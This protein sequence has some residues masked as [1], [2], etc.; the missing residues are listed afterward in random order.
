MCGE[1]T[2]RTQRRAADDRPTMGPTASVVAR[3]ARLTVRRFAPGD[4]VE[5]GELHN[6][7]AVMSYLNNG[8]S[9]PEGDV[10]EELAAWIDEYD[11]SDALGCWAI[12]E[13][14]SGRFV[15]WIHFRPR[16]RE[17]EPELGFR[18]RRACWGRGFAT[19]ASRALIDRG[20]A[21]LSIDR[22]YAH[23]MS[24]HRAS[25][26]VMEK[27]GMRLVRT[28]TADWPVR[29]PGDEYGDVEYAVTRAEWIAVRAAGE[30]PS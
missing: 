27:S 16:A 12:D 22:V 18:L 9:V 17:L 6:D 5:L 15:G 21:E 13:T 26:R 1:L 14:A 20:F 4:L 7:P 23:T 30:H 10:V 3:S 8:Q 24:V 2:D 29:I 25:R 11:E 28:F 19:E